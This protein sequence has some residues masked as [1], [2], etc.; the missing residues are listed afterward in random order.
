MTR[1]AVPRGA[2]R[3]RSESGSRRLVVMSPSVRQ[4]LRFLDELPAFGWVLQ[5]TG[6]HSHKIF[7]LSEPQRL[8]GGPQLV[9]LLLE[10]ELGERSD[11]AR[12]RLEQ[13]VHHLR[14]DGI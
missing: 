11:V 1:A 2:A 9:Q 12:Q 7:V 3:S 5:S 14:P 10:D 13:P 4:S 8:C 6:Q